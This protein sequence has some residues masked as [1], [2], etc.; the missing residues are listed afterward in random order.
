MRTVT[1]S[2]V[3][4]IHCAPRDLGIQIAVKNCYRPH[5]RRKA[6][7]Q[8]DSAIDTRRSVPY[9]PDTGLRQG[10]RLFRGRTA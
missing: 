2:N 1:I 7:A 6:V 10:D 8:N 4:Q 5:G 9:P 3:A